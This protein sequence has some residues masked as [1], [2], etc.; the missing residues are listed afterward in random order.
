MGVVDNEVI[1]F[2]IERYI[3]SNSIIY[4]VN[5]ESRVRLLISN[6]IVA[7]FTLALILWH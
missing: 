2:N 3:F 5:I 4:M 6:L 7:A 1:E